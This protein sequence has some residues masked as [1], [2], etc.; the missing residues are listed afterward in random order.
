L[1]SGSEVVVPQETH[2][3]PWPYIAVST[4]PFPGVPR[5]LT[6]VTAISSPGRPITIICVI[7]A[8]RPANQSF[9]PDSAHEFRVLQ[10][11]IPAMIEHSDEVEVTFS[12]PPRV[13]DPG[14]AGPAQRARE[15]W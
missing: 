14:P 7:T 4:S 13:P 3:A 5:P 9:S 10:E 1:P 12:D 15:R 8:H 2:G 11:G 6:F